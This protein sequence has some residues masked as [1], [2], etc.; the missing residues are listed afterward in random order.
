MSGFAPQWPPDV[1]VKSLIQDRGDPP[2]FHGPQ[3]LNPSSFGRRF[4][5]KWDIRVYFRHSIPLSFLTPSI[6]SMGWIA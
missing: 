1:F 6:L 2:G 5:S 4:Y 3:E